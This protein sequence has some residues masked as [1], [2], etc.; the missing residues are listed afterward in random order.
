MLVV[1]TDCQ[2][3]QSDAPAVILCTTKATSDAG[4]D[5]HERPLFPST[6]VIGLHPADATALSGPADGRA[7]QPSTAR[8]HLDR[9]EPSCS[10]SINR[11]SRPM[12]A[13]GPSGCPLDRKRGELDQTTSTTVGRCYTPETRWGRSVYAFGLSCCARVALATNVAFPS[14]PGA[15][16]CPDQRPASTSQCSVTI[17]LQVVCGRDGGWSRCSRGCSMPPHLRARRC[18]SSRRCSP[19]GWCSS[20]SS[21]SAS[22]GRHQDLTH[23]TGP[24][25]RLLSPWTLTALVA[26]TIA[27]YASARSLR[28]G[29]GV[30][31][32]AF[33]SVAANLSAVIGGIVCLVIAGAA[34]MPSHPAEQRQPDVFAGRVGDGS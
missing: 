17:S 15:V 3:I 23:A 24:P 34:L 28:L 18:R 9:R 30:E 12:A 2:T 29:P 10:S 11:R 5:R 31:V 19:A 16:L 33:T 4:R 1:E 6:E 25:A 21:P 27:F 8:D 20:P 32:I 26:A 7:D 14:V 22:S 13:R